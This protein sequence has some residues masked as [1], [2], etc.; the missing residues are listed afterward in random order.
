[1]EKERKVMTLRVD[2]QLKFVIEKCAIAEGYSTVN[3]WIIDIIK[4]YIENKN[5][6]K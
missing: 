3:S 5:V 6:K 2:P 4:G 1:M